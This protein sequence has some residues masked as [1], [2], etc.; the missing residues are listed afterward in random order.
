MRKN[1]TQEPTM[2]SRPWRRGWS[3]L[4][5]L[6]LL[7]TA[8]MAWSADEVVGGVANGVLR[9]PSSTQQAPIGPAVVLPPPAGAVVINFDGVSR[10]CLAVQTTA[11]RN[12]FAAQGVTFSGPGAKDGFAVFDECGNLGVSGHSTPN[13]LAWNDDAAFSN[14]GIA[15]GPETLTFSSPVSLVQ[16]NAGSRSGGTIRMEAFNASGG[17]LGS[18]SFTLSAALQTL[19]VTA[20][21]IVR[22]VITVPANSFGVLDN[23]AFVPG[24]VCN[25]VL[26]KTTFVNGDTVIAQTV[27][28]TNPTT[29]A[30]AIEFKFWFEGPNNQLASFARDGAEGSFVLSPG[31]TIGPLS[32]TLLQ[33]TAALPRGN[34]A[35]NCRFVQPVTGGPIAEDLNPFVLQ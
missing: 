24:P 2:L 27:Q 11:L 18:D 4:L 8:G 9:S 10:P 3:S 12:D 16:V 5:L 29:A 14:Q 19:R 17:S 7:G 23:L 13:F 33:V 21:G 31:Q 26:N 6:S 32:L 22:V 34:Y 20:N 15:R 1:A 28:I 35:F 25:V 30:A